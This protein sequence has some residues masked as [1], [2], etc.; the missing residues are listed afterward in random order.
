MLRSRGPPRFQSALC[1]CF[2]RTFSEQHPIPSNAFYEHHGQVN[3]IYFYRMDLRGNL[4]LEQTLHEIQRMKG[5]SNGTSTGRNIMTAMKDPTFLDFFYR[6]LQPN[7]LTI[8]KN[9]SLFGIDIDAYC[10]VYPFVS[11]C[12]RERNYVLGDDAISSLG[13]TELCDSE[14]GTILIYGGAA[15]LSEFFDPTALTFSQST[16]RVYHSIRKH[17]KLRGNLGLLHPHIAA[18]LVSSAYPDGNSLL[19]DWRGDKYSIEIID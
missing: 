16:Q 11:L 15:R 18:E 10:S 17:R 8:P 1:R 7:T 14:E 3:R 13:F 5:T 2:G 9:S 4:F 12:G 19:Y 6:M